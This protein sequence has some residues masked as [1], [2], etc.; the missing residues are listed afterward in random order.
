MAE[1]DPKY[2]HNLVHALQTRRLVIRGL[3]PL[4]LLRLQPKL[5]GEFILAQPGGDTGLD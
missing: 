5:S 4:N 2:A 1:P 3:V